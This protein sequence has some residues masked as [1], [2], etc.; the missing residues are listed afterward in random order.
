MRKSKKDILHILRDCNAVKDV[1]S[2]DASV[3]PEEGTSWAGLFEILTWRLWKN[4]NLLIFQGQSWS[5][6]EIVHNSLCWATQWH[7]PPRALPSGVFD[8]PLDEKVYRF[9]IFLNIDGAVRL[10]T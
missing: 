6:R 8:P 9:E 2:Q 1:W 3:I 4:C 7:S 5:S 10:D